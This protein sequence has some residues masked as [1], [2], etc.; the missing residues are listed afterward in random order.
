MCVHLKRDLVDAAEVC[1]GFRDD[2]GNVYEIIAW[3]PPAITEPVQ[4]ADGPM[5]MDPKDGCLEK[6]ILAAGYVIDEFGKSARRGN[7][8]RH[9]CSNCGLWWRHKP[10]ECGG[11]LLCERCGGEHREPAYNPKSYP[12]FY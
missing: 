6:A 8:F 10:I 4:M 7:A 1:R 11:F 2:Y 5:S 9:L 12:P 3:P